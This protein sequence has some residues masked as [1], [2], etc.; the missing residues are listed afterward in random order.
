MLLTPRYLG[1][2]N[3]SSEET[4]NASIL[5]DISPFTVDWTAVRTIKHTSKGGGVYESYLVP[6]LGRGMQSVVVVD[7]FKTDRDRLRILALMGI[8][9]FA[10][11]YGMAK[12]E[13]GRAPII[14]SGADTK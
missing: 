7:L 11:A 13:G 1:V 10:A 5:P 8:K 14:Y 3:M 9:S 4:F 6:I 2:A 12:K